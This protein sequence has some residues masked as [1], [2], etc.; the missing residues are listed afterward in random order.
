VPV[1]ETS[2]SPILAD[3]TDGF[4]DALDKIFDTGKGQAVVEGRR[5]EFF[6]GKR[7]LKDGTIKK[8]G[9]RYW[10]WRWKSSDTGKRKAKYGG[11]IETVPT[12]Y[13]YRRER[14]EASIAAR[15][16]E[17]LADALLRP[18]ISRLSNFDTGTE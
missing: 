6:E 5:I 2:Q 16:A 18:A 15:G 4:L 1:S 12:I 7:K 11:K 9:I 17:S 14:Y 8:T 3:D 13:Q 10:Q